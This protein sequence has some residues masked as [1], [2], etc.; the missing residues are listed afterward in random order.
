M[1]DGARARTVSIE[2]TV[3]RRPRKP[4]TETVH[5]LLRHLH[6]EGVPVPQ[7]LDADDLYEYVTLVPGDA[8]D[9]AWPAG[10][11][12]PEAARS[13]GTLLRRTHDATV[14]WAPA[15][16]ARWSVPCT[17]GPVICHGDPKPANVAWV[18]GQAA[19]LF[20]WDAA[21]PADRLSD[22][23]YALL[24]VVPVTAEAARDPDGWQTR[25][26]RAEALL[27]GYGWDGP[28]DVVDVA[29]AR[30]E[31]AIQEVLWLGE[32]GHEPHA[33]WVSEGWPTTWR[34][35]NAVAGAAR[36]L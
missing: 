26:S 13:L 5:S 23:A 8:G 6:A 17:P 31:Q 2:G 16:G 28:L 18:D 19:G 9:D 24:W 32:R 35:Q 11:L 10:Q 4:W 3:V 29:T 15:S 33:T 34:E 12:P 14:G 30:Q 20:D 7:P 1:T 21:R 27:D 25:R 22:V 36:L